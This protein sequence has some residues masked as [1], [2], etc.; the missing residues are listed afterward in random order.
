M[1]RRGSSAFWSIRRANEHRFPA[2]A[3]RSAVRVVQPVRLEVPRLARVEAPAK[4]LC[5]GSEY[6][7]RFSWVGHDLM[8]VG[9]DVHRGL[10]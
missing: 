3:H 9:L 10:P 4:A 6:D 1:H 7:A 8:N 2:D 5:R